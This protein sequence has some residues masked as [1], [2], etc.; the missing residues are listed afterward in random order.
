MFNVASNMLSREAY[1]FCKSGEQLGFRVS[2][3]L[4]VKIWISVV[5]SPAR[6]AFRNSTNA[7]SVR[8]SVPRRSCLSYG[9]AGCLQACYSVGRCSVRARG[10]VFPALF[11]LP[12]RDAVSPNA[13]A[14]CRVC[15]STKHRSAVIAKFHYTGP[16]GPARTQR[17]FAAKKSVRVRS[18]PVGP[19]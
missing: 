8:P 11:D 18:G 17:S 14:A 10:R 3:C 12:T 4:S 5:T 7:R 1:R 6:G 19:V 13:A 15:L 2:V 9:H 16:T